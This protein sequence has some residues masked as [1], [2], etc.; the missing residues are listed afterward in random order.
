[1]AM[2]GLAWF[3]RLEHCLCMTATEVINEIERLPPDEQHRVF[4]RVH[5]I[6]D[7]L[8]PDS[9]LVAMAEAE[10]GELIELTDAQFDHP[11]A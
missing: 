6:E 4:E 10:R 9:F 11:P 3:L 7:S 8:I 5:E 2:F 1:M